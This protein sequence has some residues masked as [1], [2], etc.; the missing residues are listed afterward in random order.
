MRIPA[1]HGQGREARARPALQP[2]QIGATIAACSGTAE[3]KLARPAQ[4]VLALAAGGAA[5]AGKTTALMS[6]AQAVA[7]MTKAATLAKRYKP[8]R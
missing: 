7:S 2:R 3:T 8:A 4:P 5:K 6:G 1:E